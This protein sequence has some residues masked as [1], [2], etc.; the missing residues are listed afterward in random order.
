MEATTY[1][2]P[3]VR[4]LL[5]AR[6]V[7]AKVD[8]DARPDVGERY[9]EYGWPATV[10]F[11]PDG[12]EL[13][14]YRGYLAPDALVEILKTI[15][16]AKLDAER[17][18]AAAAPYDGPM[19]EHELA[20]IARDVELQLADFYDDDA[21]GWGKL[22]KA[23]LAMD[24]EW[25]LARARAGD[26]E[27]RDHA[28]ATLDAQ[29]KLLDPVWGGMY[30]YSA[31][32][33]WEHPHFEKLMT[34]QAGALD[35]YADAYALTRDPRWLAPARAMRSY[36][37][38]FL[39]SP[40]GGF[41]ATQDADLHA[42]EPGAPFLTGHEYYPKGDR[43]RRA[44]GIPRVDAHEYGKENGLAIAAYVRLHEA[45][46]DASALAT[47][48]RAARRVLG[49]HGTGPRGGIT[50]DAD[51]SSKVL[52]LSDN[53]AFGFALVRLHEATKD[54][55]WLDEAVR[56]ASMLEREML[57]P[58]GGGFYASTADPDAVG[59]FA[60]RRKPLPEN[61]LA[62]R[63]LARLAKATGDARYSKMIAST[64]R[65]V[66]TPDAIRDRGRMIGDVLMALEETRG[67]RGSADAPHP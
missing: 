64:L 34:V 55:A 11:S 41:Y 52:F 61:V 6:F 20:W 14:K 58:K 37:D 57:D 46:G 47:A 1:R 26:A 49:T 36:I 31:A 8:V 18:P 19:T 25:A 53:A 63:F 39:T 2:D 51:P 54:H 33:D 65:A 3:A 45:T 21:G 32:G 67:A 5:D 12:V 16:E 42:H 22:Q 48:T 9:A 4:A 44:L 24:N 13:G 17:P 30:Q 62:L 7:A 66:V 56:V 35:N 60:T 29:R 50:H 38:A 40:E 27:A 59:V 10:V 28:L 23:P 15:V 43:E